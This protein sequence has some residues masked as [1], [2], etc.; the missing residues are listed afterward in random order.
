MAGVTE[1]LEDGES[2]STTAVSQ[3]F[4]VLS[5]SSFKVCN[6]V[7]EKWQKDI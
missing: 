6:F 5:V 3:E 4:V 7:L 2:Q 1:W